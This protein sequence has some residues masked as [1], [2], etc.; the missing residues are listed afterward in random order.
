MKERVM[1]SSHTL[2]GPYHSNFATTETGLP[3]NAD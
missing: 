3:I 2:I 1:G